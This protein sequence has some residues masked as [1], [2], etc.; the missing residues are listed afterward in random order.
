MKIFISHQ[1][2]LIEENRP[3]HVLSNALEAFLDF[4][5]VFPGWPPEHPASQRPLQR[6]SSQDA[7]NRI[8]LTPTASSVA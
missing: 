1:H 3:S 7:D 4:D 5:P 2:W 8:C 6:C